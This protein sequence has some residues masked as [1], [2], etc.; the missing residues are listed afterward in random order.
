L[1]RDGPSGYIANCTI[2]I[3]RTADPS[4]RLRGG[5]KRSRDSSEDEGNADDIDMEEDPQAS[6]KEN[7]Y[8]DKNVS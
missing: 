6:N 1:D 8:V 3:L 2:N 5:G 7:R 4:E